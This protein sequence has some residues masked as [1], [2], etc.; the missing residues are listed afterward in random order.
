V[1]HFPA[2]TLGWT[3]DQAYALAD[4]NADSFRLTNQWA[5]QVRARSVAGLRRA[6]ARVQGNPWANIV[7]ADRHGRAYYADDT[8]VPNVSTGLQRRCTTGA[9]SDLLVAAAGV[10]LLD[11]SRKACRWGNDRDAV[12][13]GIFGP[14]ALPRTTRRDYVANA[15]DSYWLPHAHARLEGFPQILGLEDT[16]RLLRTRLLLIQ[17]DQR[18]A[19]TDGLGPAGF[20]LRTLQQVLTGNRNLSAEL[21]RDPVVA[22]CRASGGPELAEA[23]EVL[24][25]WDLRAHVSSRGEVLWR[26]LWSRIGAPP[27]AT[28]FSA[29]DPVGT[30]RT[31]DASRP[32][33]LDALRG[34]VADLRAKGIALDVPLG[35]LQSEPRGDERIPIPGCGEGE[36]CFDKVTGDRDAQ[37]RYDPVHGSSFVMTAGF[38]SRGRPYGESVLAYS[39]SENPRSPHYADQ[40]RLF[41]AERWL[42]MRFTERQIRSDPG[43]STRVV[44]GRR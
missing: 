1:L 9:K 18:L 24:A 28:P 27:W 13:K 17:A 20:T 23:C 15:N 38:D 14:R 40:T 41:S 42:P 33:V 11:G 22:A 2:A 43:Y 12:A 7:A 5:E 16:P 44:S 8:V 25:R 35:D 26:E 37:G 21:G 29:A 34:A 19:G 6:A 36:G 30:P 39:Q 4:V 10:V 32:E 31:L 3:A